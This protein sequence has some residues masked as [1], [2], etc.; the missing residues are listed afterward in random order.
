MLDA[1][2]VDLAIG[3]P[4]TTTAGRILTRL[5]F[6]E[7]F[8]CVVRKGHP[9]ADAPLDLKAFLGLSHLLVSP[10]NERFGMVD[11]ALAR[12]GLKRRLAL[13]LSRMY[14]AP[15]LIARTPSVT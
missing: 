7:R 11:A 1:G 3:V 12:Q 13:T 14:A 2:E 9:A 8:V 15:T 10:K 6:E 4:P 5:L